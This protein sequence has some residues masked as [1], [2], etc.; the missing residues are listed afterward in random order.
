MR[1][2]TN[3]DIPF[4][5]VERILRNSKGKCAYCR[6][7]F[8]HNESSPH[9]FSIGFR[10]RRLSKTV[11]LYDPRNTVALCVGCNEIVDSHYE[12]MA[13]ILHEK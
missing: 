2:R 3:P 1:I 9:G 8:D 7:D 4:E 11:P 10:V 6:M 12:H 5:L 13:F